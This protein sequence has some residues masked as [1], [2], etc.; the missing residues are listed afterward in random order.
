MAEIPP[1]S[2]MRRDLGA[3]RLL[4]VAMY[5]L[6]PRGAT[7]PRVWAR[8]TTLAAAIGADDRTAQRHLKTLVAAG[9]IVDTENGW[10][11][12]S[13]DN[14]VGG[15]DSSVV[16]IRQ[17]CR[18]NTTGLSFPT[19]EEPLANHKDKRGHLVAP[20]PLQDEPMK[21]PNPA[22]P[23]DPTSP[24]SG[25][26]LPQDAEQL[27]LGDIDPAEPKRDAVAELWAYQDELRAWAYAKRGRSGRNAPRKLK[28]DSVARR[29]IQ[30]VLRDYTVDDARA[31]LRNAAREAATSDR[32]LSYYD[33]VS[34][35][36]PRNFA[37]LA[38]SDADLLASRNRMEIPSPDRGTLL[39][40][41]ANEDADESCGR[42]DDEL[43]RA[44]EALLAELG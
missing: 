21:P 10:L 13:G 32:S 22:D 14:T 37:R 24:P 31:T 36:R 2:L 27:Q 19:L 35:W 34:N 43:R 18:P 15:C 28:L 41:C 11:L 1:S 12:T 17:D 25:R 16:S 38:N 5:Q 7:E 8:T 23:P 42:A 29:A 9:E 20:A 44:G 26:E 30:T 4:L 33:G 6:T 3:A 40:S 39:E